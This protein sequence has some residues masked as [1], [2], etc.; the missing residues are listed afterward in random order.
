MPGTWRCGMLET[1]S[2]VFK[3]WIRQNHAV[4]I[5]PEE[6][7]ADVAKRE[8]QHYKIGTVVPRARIAIWA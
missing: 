3:Q 8:A 7:P 6:K 2:P 5:R 1:W 4:T